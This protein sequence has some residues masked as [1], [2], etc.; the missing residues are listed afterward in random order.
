MKSFENFDNAFFTKLVCI[1]SALALVFVVAAVVVGIATGDSVPTGK[2]ENLETFIFGNTA[3]PEAEK[4]ADETEALTSETEPY[5]PPVTETEADT[6]ADTMP[7]TEPF[8]T[9]ADPTLVPTEPQPTTLEE[10]EDMGQE[11]IDS[12]T[13]LGDSTT[14]GMKAYKMLKDGKNTKQIWTSKTATLSLSEIAEKEIIHPQS[15][16]EMTVAEAA[17]LEKPEYLIITLGVEGVT[18]LDEESFKAEYKSLIESI[19]QASPETKIILQSIFPVSSELKKLNN[20]LI[21]TANGWVLQIAEE[22]GL[23]YLDTQ[24]VL[25][26]ENGALKKDYDNG[27]NG[28]NLN[29]RGFSAVLDYIRTHG[30]K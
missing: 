11:Y 29:D 22:Y 9:E 30:Y 20:P 10:S 25:K 13:F 1:I 18:F 3:S 17:K 5:V 28:I 7:D 19:I 26:D 14:Y 6:E 24:S 21:D 27:G 12:L 2:K 15:G 4:E 8:D 16:K 23:R